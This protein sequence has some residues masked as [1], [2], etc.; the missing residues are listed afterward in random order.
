[1]LETFTPPIDNNVNAAYGRALLK[2]GQSVTVQR[3]TGTAPNVTIVSAVVIALVRDAAPDGQAAS[4]A[5]YS[6]GQ[7]GGITQTARQVILMSSDLAAA[8]FPLPVQKGDKIILSST[9][10]KL[11]VTEVDTGKRGI[12]GATQ[13]TGAGVP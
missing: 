13:L 8:N 3:L 9:G 10:E 5:G 4:Q 11:N 12:A 2:T 7:P 1:M 6:G